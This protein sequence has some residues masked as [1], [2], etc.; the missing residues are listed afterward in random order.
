MLVEAVMLFDGWRWRMLGCW[1]S[2]PVACGILVDFVS[3]FLSC[4]SCAACLPFLPAGLVPGLLPGCFERL[5][6]FSK[7]LTQG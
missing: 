1:P 2:R 7:F 3:E 4:R 6:F 5:Y